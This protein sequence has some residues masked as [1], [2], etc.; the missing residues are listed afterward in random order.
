[1]PSGNFIITGKLGAGKSLCAMGKIREALVEGRKVATNLDI[2]LSKLVGKKSKECVVYRVPDHPTLES[3][4]GIGQGYE[5][6]Y[7]EEK[8]G[9]ILLDECGTWLNSRDW[10]DK[11]RRPMLDYLLHIRK[12]RWQIYLLVQDISIIDKQF[13]KILGEHVV[14]CRRFDRM[15]VPFVGFWY[16]LITGKKL[17]LLQLHVGVV[18]YG[19]LPSSMTVDSWLFRGKD[20]YN[21]YDT[22]QMF[23]EDSSAAIYQL[24]PPYFLHRNSLAKRNLRFYMRMTKIVARKYSRVFAFLAGGALLTAINIADRHYFKGDVLGV[25]Q[26]A[27]KAEAKVADSS[28]DS[29]YVDPGKVTIEVF[30]GLQITAFFNGRKPSYFFKDAS[31]NTYNT[32]D[33]TDRGF[34]IRGKGRCKAVL[35]KDKKELTVYCNSVYKDVDIASAGSSQVITL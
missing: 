11:Q 9:I 7:D 8:T 24:V 4:Q 27:S 12:H 18:K 20:L 33:I 35:L 26:S 17:S 16:S 22:E 1:M 23:S 31:G 2:N 19:D 32:R 6:E 14:Y 13:R 34:A 5:G 30:N 28:T 21:T 10:Q 29:V 3:L 15:K 25:V